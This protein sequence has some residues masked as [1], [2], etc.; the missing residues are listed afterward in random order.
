MVKHQRRSHQHGIHP[1]EL[2]GGDTSDSEGESPST[3]QQLRQL[4]FPPNAISSRSAMPVRH[5]LHREHFF[6]DFGH[7][8]SQPYPLPHRYGHGHN[9]SSGPQAFNSPIPEHNPLISRA[10]SLPAHSSFYVT[11]QNNPG[12]WATLGMNPLQYQTCQLSRQ[13][14][15]Q[16]MH[17]SSLSSYSLVLRASPLGEPYYDQPTAQV[18]RRAI[19]SSPRAELMHAVQFQQPL[20]QSLAQQQYQPSPS[21][22]GLWYEN[23][24][25]QSPIEIVSQMQAY[26]ERISANPWIEKIEAYD[27]LSLQMPRM[28]IENL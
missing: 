5:Q 16:E 23:V 12:V 18:A 8:Q 3:P 6:A 1:S 26:Q 17:Q 28:R 14:Q 10:P 7:Q 22:D 13:R 11:E 15:S 9:L 21:Q 27:D 24:S 2:Y 4:Q 19:H 25:Y 20:A